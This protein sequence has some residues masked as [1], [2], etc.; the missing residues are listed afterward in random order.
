ME[1]H[2][3][4]TQTA[5]Q[6]AT[7]ATKEPPAAASEPTTSEQTTKPTVEKQQPTQPANT[8]TSAADMIMQRINRIKESKRQLEDLDKKQKAQME[9]NSTTD[10]EKKASSKRT[11]KD[12]NNQ[13]IIDKF[14]DEEPSIQPADPDTL[15]EGDLTVE[16]TASTDDEIIT[17]SLARVYADQNYY[18]KAINVYEKLILKYPE[19]KAYF[20]QQINE[21]KK[22]LDK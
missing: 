14:I 17:E 13:E 21:L 15:K 1:T 4:L 20:A 12:K 5:S 10:Q 22:K 7:T 16:Q 8:S 2:E 18:S 19:K 9:Q 6:A 11:L 3:P